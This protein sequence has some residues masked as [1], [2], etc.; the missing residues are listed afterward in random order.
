M[1]I[2]LFVSVAARAQPAATPQLLL[3]QTLDPR[4]VILISAL[5]GAV[6]FSVLSAIALI[7]ARKPYELLLFPDERH[8]PRRLE[9]RV[10]MEEQI[11][12]YIQKHLE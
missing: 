2:S 8:M 3:S 6:I 4:E 5:L 9:D 12:A 7:R 11:F 10:H 1:W